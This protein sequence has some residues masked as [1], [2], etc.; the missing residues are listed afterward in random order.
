MKIVLCVVVIMLLVGVKLYVDRK[1]YKKRM[2]KRLL[3][4]W[5]S[6]IEDEYSTEKLQAV[7]EYYRDH[8]PSIFVDD[9]TWNDLDMNRVYQQMNHTKSA[10]G[11]EYL[12]YLLRCPVTDPKELEERERLISFFRTEEE[13]RYML[14]GEFATIGKSGNFSVYGYLDKINLLKRETGIFSI[15]QF[16][17]FIGGVISCFFVPDM[18]IMPTA[19][20]AAV[21]MVTYYKRKAQMEQFYRLF[22]FVVR[23]IRFSE[24]VSAMKIK[25]LQTYFDRMKEKQGKFR[26]FCRGSWLVV[27]GGRMEGNITDIL[28]DYVRLLTHIDIIKFQ[29]M[30]REGYR[31]LLHLGRYCIHLSVHCQQGQ[32]PRSR[33]VQLP[34]RG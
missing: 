22:A 7:A 2:R 24:T 23:M 21:N 8:E 33:M 31:L 9:I 25:E 1:N 13:A 18:M 26:K 20:I 27:G 14:Q 32:R 10:M 28:M 30:A 19:V 29:S 5:G 3:R 4:E 11:Q 16:V 15:I 12:Y 17:A 34:V 6:P